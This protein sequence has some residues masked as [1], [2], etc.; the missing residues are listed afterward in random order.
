MLDSTANTKIQHALSALDRALAAGDIDAALR[1]FT[2][3]CYW[4]DFLTF[5]WNL[6]TLAGQD[7]VRAMLEARLKDV[8]PSAWAMPE[9]EVASSADGVTEGFIQFETRV[10]RGEGYIKLKDGRIWIL[11]TTMKE[12]KGHEEPLGPTRPFGAGHGSHLGDPTWLEKREKEKAELGI[13]TQPY[14]LVVGGAQAGIILG[15]R[16]KQLGVPTLIVEKHAHPGDNWRSRYKSLCLHDPVWYD[17]L[18]YIKFPQNWPVF[19]PKDKIADW[20][21]MF[22]TVMELD[23][24][25]NTEAKKATYDEKTGT[26]SV[27]VVRDG[28]EITLKPKQLVLATGMSGKPNQPN[29]PGQDRFLGIQQHSSEHPGPDG[30][31]G[32]KVVVIGSNNSA[33]DIC[34]ALAEN[35]VDVTMVQ[36]SST[37]VSRSASLMKHAL[38]PLYSE[39]A[40]AAGITTEKADLL[41][42]A[43][44]YALMTGAL[45]AST[46]A[47]KKDDAQ[48]YA[49][50]KKRGF[51]L[52]FGPEDAGLFALYLFRASGYY[53]DI[54]AS[55]LI[56]D[57]KIKLESGSEVEGLKEHS[58]V[59]KDGREIPADAVIYATGYA[60]MNSFAAD[61]ISKDVANKVG[62]CWGVG[63]NTALDP[64][65]WEGEQRN[66][67]KP[68]QQPGL[69][70]EGG[71]LAQSRFYSR[72]MALQ[73]KARMEG[74]P[75]PVYGLQP[76]HHKEFERAK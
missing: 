5:T 25:G 68:T 3:D 72:Y 54:G 64:G 61:L 67:W 41:F 52:N 18:P 26:W 55:Q 23:Y 9:G 39:E 36:R 59:L 15:A 49:G 31:K 10:A 7:E 22:A 46:E 21:D 76:V 13:K 70:F 17:H 16:L 57:G 40:V 8:Q 20:L 45:Q 38:G 56:I 33:H 2:P 65:P 43:I 1:L 44:P 69:W 71:N 42:A 6:K 73:L 4:R 47:I 50:L 32:K 11:L 27:K 63:S 51:M 12:L 75:T 28:K 62:K 24:W 37:H 58:V 48:F 14:V 66:M 53:I 30:F 35:G 34:G 60:S 29:F 74:I 19:S